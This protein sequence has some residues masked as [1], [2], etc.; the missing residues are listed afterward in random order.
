[1]FQLN[2]FFITDETVLVEA[3]V[4][5]FDIFYIVLYLHYYLVSVKLLFNLCEVIAEISN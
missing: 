4:T 3:P 1:M 5:D 2:K